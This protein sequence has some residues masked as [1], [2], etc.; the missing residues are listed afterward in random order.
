MWS[1]FSQ[2]IKG[3]F[4][5]S[6][7]VSLS[8]CSD[9][10]EATALS[11]LLKA[12]ALDKDHDVPQGCA[13]FNG[14]AL[15]SREGEEGAVVGGF[16]EGHCFEVLCRLRRCTKYGIPGRGRQPSAVSAQMTVQTIGSS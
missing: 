8:G 11:E 2:R 9:G 7:L 3:S 6:S 15:F 16:D 12:L 1:S 10:S 4:D 5:V 13:D 14:V